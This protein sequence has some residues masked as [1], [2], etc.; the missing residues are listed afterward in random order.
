[1]SEG[2]K[3][4]LRKVTGD[5]PASTEQEIRD[6]LQRGQCKPADFLFDFTAARWFRLGDHPAFTPLLGA[7]PAAAPERKLIYILPPGST[8][9]PQGPFATREVQQKIQSR[10][11]CESTWVFVEGDKEWRQIRGVKILLDMLPALPTEAPAAAAPAPA[12]S[13]SAAEPAH[14]TNPSISIESDGADAP[15]GAPD[16]HVEEEEHTMAFSTLGLSLK[17]EHNK[18]PP[19]KAAA[20][21]PGIPAAPAVPKPIP[22]VPAPQPVP[23]PAAVAAKPQPD[24]DQGSFDGITAEIPADPIWLIKQGNSETVAGPFRFL[25][26]M[27]LIEE[28]KVTKNDKISRVGSN[29]FV[30][31]LQQYEFNVKYSVETV[32]ERGMEIQKILIRRRHPRVPYITGVQVVSRH[33]LLAGNCVNVSAGGI[34]M[35]LAKAEFNLGEI[36]EIKILPGLI[37]RSISCKALVIGK[38]P[39]APPGYALKF[40]DLKHEDKEAIE[41]FVQ[42]SLKREMSQR[43]G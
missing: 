6:W 42:E 8:P 30:K 1:M 10:E 24:P 4:L 43:N 11:V 25:E 28:G 37:N 38:I 26:V 18:A 12:S 17:E 39:K 14:Q 5:Q 35:E 29:R 22:P 34:L 40:E 19:P 27:K 15:A 13:A 21:L 20:P 33:G 31:I 32:M 3:F 23:I 16:Y 36:L 9:I 41:H 2:I 7:K